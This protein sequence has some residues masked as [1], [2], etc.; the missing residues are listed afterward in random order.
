MRVGVPFFEPSAYP[1]RIQ[2][3]GGDPFPLRL[4]RARPAGGVALVREWVADITE[5]SC[6]GEDLDAL[7]LA[8]DEPAELAGLLLAAIRLDLPTVCAGP[9]AGSPLAI[10]FAALGVSPV[11]EDA[12]KV[13]VSIARSGGPR[14]G[15]L[16]ENFSLANALRAGLAAGGG[17]ELL[18]H[19]AAVAREAHSAGF[20]Q[21]IRVLTPETTAL[22]APGSDWLARYGVAGL[23][24]TLGDSLHEAPSVVGS[25]KQTLPDAPPAPEGEGSR[26]VFVRGRA[27][28]TEA[29]CRISG[30]TQEVSGECRVFDGEEAAVRA[31][32]RGKISASEL[33]VVR[34]CGPCGGLGLPVL[35]RLANALRNMNAGNVPVL[36]DGVAP[37]DADGTWTS[38]VTPESAF[39]GVLGLLRDGDSLTLDLAEGRILAD[40]DA[41]E[42]SR[43]ETIVS[44]APAGAGYAARY[45][46]SARPALE[47][48]GFGR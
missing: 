25:L 24:A 12:A 29:V 7:L 15:E 18:I 20:S 44:E 16:V 14:P 22:A 39:G 34:G 4:P 11:S 48:A 33:L 2:A 37:D 6:A 45:A 23:L 10:S 35:R 46:H 38:L 13:A 17:P 1:D 41:K 3:A 40:I 31:V 36:T 43:R 8:A 42:L 32:S 47:G 21:T 9:A 26:M 27:S 5:V 30:A 28:G 19:L